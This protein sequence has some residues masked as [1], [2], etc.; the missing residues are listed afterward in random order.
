MTKVF[1]L[2][3][4]LP[5]TGCGSTEISQ[6]AGP[7]GVRCP[8]E[9]TGLPT[10]VPATASQP[11]GVVAT[12]RECSWTATS[13][14]PW[15]TVNP[16]SGQG[17]TTLTLSIAANGTSSSRSATLIVNDAHVTLTQ[18]AGPSQQPPTLTFS[19]SVSSVGGACP[20]ITFNVAGRQVVTDASTRFSG[21]NCSS[22]RNGRSVEIEGEP[23][24]GNVVRA[25]RVRL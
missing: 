20:V 10:S 6:L 8:T 12:E 17:E 13:S 5:V 18:A 2:L 11:T 19:G 22:V 3:A 15:L 7:D 23:I 21:G 16:A 24:S 1:L 25:T 4:L 14:A 9:I